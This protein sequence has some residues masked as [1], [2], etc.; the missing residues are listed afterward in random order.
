MDGRPRLHP[1][2]TRDRHLIDPTSTLDGPRV[3]PK[4]VLNRPRIDPESPR[5][6]SGS[7][8]D[9]P[10]IDLGSTLDR[11]RIETTSTRHRP[12]IDHASAQIRPR[13][14]PGSPPPRDSKSVPD[15]PLVDLKTPPIRGVPKV[16]TPN[17]SILS[18]PRIHPR[19]DPESS[20]TR[21]QVG[22]RPTLHGRP[23]VPA[24]AAPDSKW[25][26]AA[27]AWCAGIRPSHGL[28]W[29]GPWR[30]H[31]RRRWQR[32]IAPGFESLCRAS[33]H[34]VG[35]RTDSQRDPMS[36]HPPR[37]WPGSRWQP[38]TAPAGAA[39]IAAA[40]AVAVGCCRGSAARTSTTTTTLRRGRPGAAASGRVTIHGRE[41]PL[42]KRL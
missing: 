13:I 6:N 14:E 29:Y 20:T 32:V 19:I 37:A 33:S 24:R 28:R 16:D 27:I 10:R 12:R 17:R 39:Q 11:P 25:R 36:A 38:A 23:G 21:P 7:A 1:K 9:R 3:D 42:T 30:S 34:S 4:S 40:R 5:I 18:P 41:A 26:V 35:L 2:S 31:G 8:V 15:G 22:P